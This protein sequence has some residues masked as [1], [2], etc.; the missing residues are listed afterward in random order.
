[1][2]WLVLT[3]VLLFPLPANADPCGPQDYTRASPPP[4]FD[5]PSP[6]EETLV[7]KPEHGLKDSIKLLTTK[8]APWDGI[9]MDSD[10][11]IQLGLRIT[12]LRRLR[13]MDTLTAIDK[14]KMEVKL[15]EDSKKA[16]INLVT[17]QRESYKVQLQETQKELSKAK[18]WY[19]SWTFGLIVGVVTTSAAAVT[20]AYVARK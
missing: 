10:R 18:A 16:D 2:R 17:S 5:C 6:L 4:N 15:V 9:L 7:P 19:R 8:P 12:A 20:L 11:V 3:L 14:T 13:W 1:M